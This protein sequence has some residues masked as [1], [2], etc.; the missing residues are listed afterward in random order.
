M[1]VNLVDPQEQPLKSPCISVCALDDAG[2]C[3]GCYRTGR[4]IS[5][6]R[7]YSNDERRQVLAQAHQREKA[8][9]PFL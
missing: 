7:A 5:E 9:N 4:E 6:W 2:V 8:V 3:I 1:S